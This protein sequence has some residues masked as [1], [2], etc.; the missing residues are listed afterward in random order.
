MSAKQLPV[1][2]LRN[3]VLFPGVVLRLEVEGESW[4]R[5]HDALEQTPERRA[6]VVSHPESEGPPAPPEMGVEAE[7]LGTT[8]R[9]PGHYGFLLRG[10]ARRRLGMIQTGLV[11]HAAALPAQELGAAD[12]T[13]PTLVKEIRAGLRKL[14]QLGTPLS[15][16]L[17][18]AVDDAD[19]PSAVADLVGAHLNLP[20][21]D[22]M[23]LLGELD[24]RVRLERVFTALSVQ[25]ETN[26]RATQGD[27]KLREKILR[28]RLHAIEEE[29][30]DPGADPGLAELAKKLDEAGLPE[31]AE[32]AARRELRRL[33]GN[34]GQSPDAQVSRTYLDWLVSLPW[35]KK[36]ADKID[37]AAA[38]EVLDGDHYGMDKL[39]QRIVEYMAVRKLKPNKKGPILLFVGPPGVGKTSLARSIAKSLGREYVR[40][41]L[42]G[43][44]DEAEIRGHRRT[45]IGALPGRII[46][47]LKRAGTR[48][49]VFVLDELDKLGADFRGDPSAALLEVLDPEQNDTFSDHYLE[50][51]FDLSEVIFIGTANDVSQIPGPLRDRMEVMTL[52]GYPPS[53]KRQIARHHLVPRQLAEH[54]LVPEHL[55]FTDAALDEIIDRYTMEAGVRNLEREIASVVRGVG[56]KVAAGETYSTEVGPVDVHRYLGP[57][58]F[59]PE[60][61]EQ[62]AQPG[63]ATGMAWTPTGGEILFIEASEMP[64]KGNLVLTGQLGDV[65][66][67]SAQAAFSYVRSHAADLGIDSEALGKR[68]VHI[69]VPAGAMPKDGPS[70]GN[71]ILTSM[72]SLLTGRAVESDIAMTGE[73]TLRGH[74]LPVGGIASKVLAAHRAG[75]KRIVLPDRNA[76]DV[77]DIPPE[78]RSEL[79]IVFV[80]RVAQTLEL[81]LRPLVTER[82]HA[83]PEM[84]AAA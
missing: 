4:G 34:G 41:S 71:A 67:E 27:P 48:N 68:D 69:H 38:R 32:K 64:G 13:V 15:E 74:V 52:T 80:N 50:V 72:V 49:P 18:Q 11:P 1:V 54:G 40:V 20:Y 65:M 19:G 63:V 46:Q 33:R 10:L 24:V 42:G 60:V 59:Y 8:K 9:S 14:E 51:P 55:T 22:K 6:L 25:V 16:G 73:I 53:D 77:D 78:V 47:G 56:V 17:T 2:S 58:K 26:E 37:L 3:L 12:P 62:T 82:S 43:V 35:S 36:T 76:K 75:I 83:Q 70:A 30:G 29:L 45:Y 61:A 23:M 57:P 84:L 7:I 39:K 81:A 5:L 79:E 66:R 44:R 28:E 21:A 31:E